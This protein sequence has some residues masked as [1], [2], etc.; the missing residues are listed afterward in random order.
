[1]TVGQ[2]FFGKEETINTNE[3]VTSRIQLTYYKDRRGDRSAAVLSKYKKSF[4]LPPSACRR[5]SYSKL[6]KTRSFGV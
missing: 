1:M 4:I 2:V 3:L 6:P 5:V